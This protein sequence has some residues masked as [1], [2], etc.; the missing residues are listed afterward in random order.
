M[1]LLPIL[2]VGLVV[3]TVVSLIMWKKE[4]DKEKQERDKEIAE[5]KKACKSNCQLQQNMCNEECSSKCVEDN[6][7]LCQQRCAEMCNAGGMACSTACD[8]PNSM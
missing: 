4:S 6:N 1:K 5:R 3:I 7:M 2:I 8:N